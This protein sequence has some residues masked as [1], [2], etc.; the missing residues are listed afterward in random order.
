M[1]ILFEFYKKMITFA[2]EMVELTTLPPQ[3]L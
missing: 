2:V 3:F 1:T